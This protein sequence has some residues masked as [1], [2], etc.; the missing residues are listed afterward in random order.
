MSKNSY[1]DYRET[2][3]GKGSWAEGY[4]Q[5]LFNPES[6]DYLMWQRERRVI[7][8]LIEKW[9]TNFEKYLDFACGTGRVLSHLE[10]RFVHSTGIDISPDMLSQAKSKIKKAELICGD[11][12]QN[13]D[14][15][16]GTFDCITAF[17]FFLHAQQALRDEAMDF[18]A[19]RLRDTSSILIFNIHGNRY[20]TRLPVVLIDRLRGKQNSDMSVSDVYALTARH[21]LEIVD[22]RGINFL[23]KSFYNYM[24]KG[25][26]RF[27]DNALGKISWMK[28]HAV[29]MIYVCKKRT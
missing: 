7:D 26:W 6:Y 11:A 17:R 16:D 2:H 27:A 14:L 20:S 4:D 13:P 1:R 9:A 25:V 18:L 8:D 23:D 21:G 24:P 12:T 28:N 3:K 29:Y 22:Q 5:V 15:I 19:G 10:S